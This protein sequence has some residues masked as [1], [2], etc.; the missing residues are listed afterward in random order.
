MEQ[1]LAEIYGANEGG[2]ALAA[3][4]ETVAAGAVQI[5]GTVAESAK[6]SSSG[7]HRGEEEGGG[8]GGEGDGEGED[9]EEGDGGE[10]DEEEEEN[11]ERE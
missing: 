4:K 7:D 11:E 10:D 1:H 8:G 9:A 6:E 3:L 5:S 2:Q